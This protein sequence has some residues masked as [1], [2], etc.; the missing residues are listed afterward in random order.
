MVDVFYSGG[1]HAPF[2]HGL[3]DISVSTKSKTHEKKK[4]TVKILNISYV[5][6]TKK[7]SLNLSMYEKKR[8][9]RIQRKGNSWVKKSKYLQLEN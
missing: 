1:L 7:I 4:F 3:K 6:T 5:Y 2:I 9:E 8:N